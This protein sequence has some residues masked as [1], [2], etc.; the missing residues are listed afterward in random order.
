MSQ[1]HSVESSSRSSSAQSINPAL[2]A[3]LGSL[4]VH[5]EEELSRYRR[6][7]AGRGV[8]PNR[9]MGHNQVRKPIDMISVNAT[10]GR[11]PSPA[12]K[13]AYSTPAIPASEPPLAAQE[14][15]AVEQTHKEPIETHSAA[16]PSFNLAAASDI[17]I[18]RAPEAAPPEVPAPP[19]PIDQAATTIQPD[20]YLESSEQLLRS[21]AQ[22]EA[23]ARSQRSFLDNILTPLGVGSLLLLLFSTAML[24]YVV[25]NPSTLSSLG[26]DRF[27]K[28]STP[29]VA[30]SPTATTPQTNASPATDTGKPNGPDLSSDEFKDLNLDTLST[31]K[32]TPSSSSRTPQ[33]AVPS[34]QVSVPPIAPLPNPPAIESTTDVPSGTGAIVPVRPPAPLPVL[35]ARSPVAAT[36]PSAQ[37]SA[38]PTVTEPAPPNPEGFYYV[39]VKYNGPSSFEE[40]RKVVPD[41]YMSPQGTQIY[42]GAFKKDSEAKTLV[43]ELQKQGISA[44][45]Y[46]P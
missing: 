5:L 7:R 45:V 12:P 25:T 31:L 6:E 24:G 10:G 32:P 39:V 21:L 15:K 46:Q 20:D 17:P 44:S 8:P 9:G 18:P 38:S 33:V 35:P 4:D 36:T 41:A 26:L 30:Q 37:P 40:A 1:G 27:W 16:M 34:P 29:T 42:L 11:N 3:A 14:I 22:E 23:A 28:S 19:E 2:Q 43:T 13:E